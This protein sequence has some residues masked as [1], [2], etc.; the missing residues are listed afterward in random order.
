MVIP[1]H[2]AS[3]LTPRMSFASPPLIE[4]RGLADRVTIEAGNFLEWAEPVLQA[5]DR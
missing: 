4:A 3:Y 2:A 1:E 5:F